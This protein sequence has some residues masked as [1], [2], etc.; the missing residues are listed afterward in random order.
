MS[1]IK[2]SIS[3]EMIKHLA[4]QLVDF[5]SKIYT[6]DVR[7][8]LNR[9][10]KNLDELEEESNGGYILAIQLNN[11]LKRFLE[12]MEINE[13]DSEYVRQMTI[14]MIY[15]NIPNLIERNEGPLIS[16]AMLENYAIRYA[17][18]A[19]LHM[20]MDKTKEGDQSVAE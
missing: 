9:I 13:S 1:A 4:A 2:T 10:S 18:N 11:I 14:K 16:K 15:R 3:S 8:D 5:S 6:A 19:V 7:I 17:A 20:A 12:S